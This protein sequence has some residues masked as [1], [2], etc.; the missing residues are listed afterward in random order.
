VPGT[1]FFVMT[2]VNSAGTE[3]QRSNAASKTIL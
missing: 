2:S 1:Y 3:S